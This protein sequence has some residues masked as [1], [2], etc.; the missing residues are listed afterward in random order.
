[1]FHS[2]TA[3]LLRAA[4]IFGADR[5]R[6][7]RPDQRLS[8]AVAR[9]RIPT[10]RGGSGESAEPGL[11]ILIVTSEA[12]PVVSGI[13][14]AVA[15]LRR[16]LTDQGHHVDVVSRDDFPRF[17]RGEFRFSAF[18]FYWPALRRRLST[19]DVVNLHGPVPTISEVFLLLTRTLRRH[20]RPAI[21]YTHH[22]DLSITSLQRA[23]SV[24]NGIAGR[25][26]Q[27]ADAIVVSSTAYHAKL[28]RPSGKPV[29]IIPWAI[30][31]AGRQLGERAA[32][33]HSAQHGRLRVL[34]VGQ[35]RGYKGLH[36]LLDAVTGLRNVSLTIVGDGPLRPELDGRVAEAGLANVRLTGRL[37][38]VELRDAYASHD[39]IVLPSTTTAEAYGLVLAEG[40]AAG[41][42]PVASALPGVSE[43][44]RDTGLL[45][46]PG[47][48]RS[49]RA[50]FRTLA[51]QPRL[52]DRLS[53]ASLERAGH[54]SV[55]AMA[56]Q[57]ERVFRAAQRAWREACPSTGG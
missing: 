49:L 29:S 40:M 46:R 42:V 54:L 27:S 25:V 55:D 1:M 36:V 16:G 11:A 24:Y 28:D 10:Q 53:A 47:D 35:L 57:Y 26:A 6:G 13:S 56:R 19:Y 3:P 51:D 37:P 31:S 17:I 15:V 50:A 48:S 44:A 23:C 52:V 2:G 14:T 21:V 20:Q 22:S 43:L 5:R 39:V 30:D 38:D 32:A 34:F 7:H 12:P 33:G 41:C 4:R 18:A 45:V 8:A 9:H